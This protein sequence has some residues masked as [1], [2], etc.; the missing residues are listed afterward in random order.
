MSK[1]AEKLIRKRRFLI[2]KTKKIIKKRHKKN[3]KKK[4][5]KVT[6]SIYINRSYNDKNS[7]IIKVLEHSNFYKKVRRKKGDKELK[8]NIP[9]IFSFINNPDETIL[10][11]KKIYYAGTNSHISSIYF[12][13]SQCEELGL[14]ASLVTDL[15]ILSLPRYKTKKIH[16]HGSTPNSIDARKLFNITGL[17]KHLGI[18]DASTPDSEILDILSNIE[19]G[20]MAEQVVN[21]YQKCLNTQGYELT[22]LGKNAFSSMIGEVINNSE[23]YSG[24]NGTWHALGYFDK[25][26]VGEDYGK[27]RLVLMNFGNSIYESLKEAD[28]TEYTKNQLKNHTKKNYNFLD[29]F[30]YTEEILWTLY[31]L[32]Q[33]I[34]KKRKDINDDRGNGTIKLIKSFMDIGANI[35][36]K[37]SLMSITSGKCQILFDG[38]YKLEKKVNKDKKYYQIAFNDSNNLNNKPDKR[39]VYNL[40]NKFPGTI[41]SMEFYL[42]RKFFNMLLNKEE[43]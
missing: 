37:K 15:I 25:P 29:Q 13:Y 2:N 12:N 6:N 28:T 31:S 22:M 27:C 36:N 23:Q 19:S 20:E 17:P 42:D 21:F 33:N 38:T 35:D 3:R 11:L 40:Q 41:I 30:T 24:E 7:K 1:K 5:K 4:T 8:I 10:T 14:C 26:E 18:H 39:F 34:S 32:Q 9:R 43:N 16:L